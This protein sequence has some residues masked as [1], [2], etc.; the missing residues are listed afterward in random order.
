LKF[1]K[2]PLKRL[3]CKHQWEFKY[4]HAQV[5]MKTIEQH[6]KVMLG[7]YDYPSSEYTEYVETE[8]ELLSKIIC[9]KC[10][11]EEVGYNVSPIMWRKMSQQ[12]YDAYL[13]I[14]KNQKQL[15]QDVLAKTPLSFF[16]MEICG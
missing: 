4:T 15:A 14:H 6:P 7:M 16:S 2:K 3:W 9:V 10:E 11:K 8:G 5:L 13:K 1:L 12:E